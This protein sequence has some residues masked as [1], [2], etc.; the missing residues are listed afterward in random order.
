MLLIPF[1]TLIFALLFF[2]FYKKATILIP[3]NIF[4]MLLF[5]IIVVVTRPFDLGDTQNY[6]DLFH[7]L[8][9]SG[10]D[11]TRFRSE[12]GFLL[13]TFALSSF[14]SDRGYLLA[15]CL[16]QTFLWLYFFRRNLDNNSFQ[17]CVFFFISFFASYTLGTNVLRQGIAIPMV[18]IG[19]SFL[20]NNKKPA[21]I[22]FSLFAFLFHSSSL[23]IVLCSLVAY[24]FNFRLLYYFLIWFIILVLAKVG[25]FDLVISN[26]F[27]DLGYGH[28]VRDGAFDKYE[29]GFRLDFTL[30]S[31]LPLIVYFFIHKYFLSD[32]F[33]KL[34]L[35]LNSILLMTYSIPYS[36]RV[37][38][39]SWSLIPLFFGFLFMNYKT[40]VIYH[41]I[42][43]IFIYIVGFLSFLFYSV[44][45]F[46]YSFS[47]IF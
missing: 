31:L 27:Q 21:F 17:I 5:Y 13:L 7:T 42:I 45:S 37:G 11:F 47:N 26:V 40:H 16:F 18:L 44:M 39:L 41:A 4:F 2:S 6:L 36:D 43:L 46:S 33:M 1:Y 15:I 3:I 12:N 32:Y 24:Y 19:V 34:Y 35:A 25:L 30:F 28:I 9:D 14:I 10:L 29:T 8:R 20:F 38:I 23:L 22:V